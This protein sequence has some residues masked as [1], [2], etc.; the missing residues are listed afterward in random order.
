MNNIILSLL[1]ALIGGLIGTY[2]GSYFFF[3]LVENKMK[4]VRNIAIKALKILE[5]YTK[6][7]YRDA[8]NEFNNTLTITEKRTIAV[9]LHKLGV[10]FEIP[11]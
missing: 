6:Q 5:K 3:F 7:S 9:A 2:C 1:I 10:P 4:K 8:E 11:L